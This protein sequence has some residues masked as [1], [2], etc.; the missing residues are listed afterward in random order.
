MKNF[1]SMA[2][3]KENQ[4]FGFAKFYSNVMLVYDHVRIP[5]R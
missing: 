5:Y 2:I 1:I 3:G 4:H